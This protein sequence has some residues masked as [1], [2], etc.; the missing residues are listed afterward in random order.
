MGARSKS[1]R[2]ATTCVRR[3]TRSFERGQAK[4]DEASP[5]SSQPHVELMRPWIDLSP[6][7]LDEGLLSQ[8]RD[9]PKYSF[10]RQ[11]WPIQDAG[12]AGKEAG[13]SLAAT[14]TTP[15]TGEC[16]DPERPEERHQ[17]KRHENHL[18]T[19][20]HQPDRNRQ[21]RM[22]P[23]GPVKMRY[24]AY[25]PRLC[26]DVQLFDPGGCRPLVSSEAG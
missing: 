3:W 9:Q 5:T 10:R 15:P 13:R 2:N 20:I 22:F 23:L 6:S 24:G 11:L 17:K 4:W 25:A 16:E 14:S 26:R 7:L 1:S 8:E 18:D 19:S 21:T 12:V